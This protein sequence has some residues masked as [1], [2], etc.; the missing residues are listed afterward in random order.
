MVTEHQQS[1]TSTHSS[2]R[3]QRSKVRYEPGIEPKRSGRLISLASLAA[4]FR[5][6]G[7]LL[8]AALKAEALAANW[9]SI[10]CR[11]RKRRGGYCI[12]GAL[13]TLASRF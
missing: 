4:N 6:P 7:V 12:V 11:Q 2:T 5:L 1:N 3:A 9:F 13:Q 10:R 8:V